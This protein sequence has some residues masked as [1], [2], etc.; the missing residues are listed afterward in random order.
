MSE[1]NRN[2]HSSAEAGMP[3]ARAR[4]LA[5]AIQ[6]EE[7]GISETVK[8]SVYSIMG[9][10]VL[11]L[12]W[13][14]FTEVSEV[15]T[16]RGKVVPVGYIHNIQHLEGGIVNNIHVRDGDRVVAGDL[17]VSFSPPATESDF[18]QLI[19]RKVFVDLDLARLS[20]LRDGT[21]FRLP[22]SLRDYPMLAAKELEATNIQRSSY[23]SELDVIDARIE[24]R[25][26]EVD[27]Q[28]NQVLVL[29]EEVSLLQQQVDI[30]TELAKK[31]AISQTDLLSVQSQHAAL[32]TD[33]REAQDNVEV[34][35]VT[36]DEERMR[37]SEAMARQ[38]KEIEDEA[39]RAQAQLA[40]VD[41][42]LVKAKDK[43]DRL[44]VYAPVSGIIQGLEVTTINSV[45]RPGDVIMQ[46]VPVDDEM[47]VESRLMPDEVG[48]ITPGQVAD[49]KVDSY[50]ATRF[51]TIK[52]TVTQI[53]PSTY[54][55][56][57]ANPYY[58]VKV[59]LEKTF[60]GQSVGEMDVI[61]GMTVQADIITGSKSI[62][63]YLMKPVTRGFSS[64]FQQR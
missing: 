26:R 25:S 45:V 3:R 1:S 12:A 20:A 35:R 28:L 34:A 63:E 39:A 52:G 54:L 57:E 37:R 33:L 13:M 44:Q 64:A 23:H 56:E 27:R 51:G 32:V 4:F 47:I 2:R 29:Q 10:L 36:L 38:R 43:L 9:L 49:V 41:T 6:L 31:N 58:K 7:E 8:Y 22:E 42:A 17:L 53:S 18:D 48:Y 11:I 5:Q 55:D 15:T 50:D 16:T 24:Q 62:M 19:I 14:T 61:P 40:E 30:R 60:M 46:V 59:S 21:E